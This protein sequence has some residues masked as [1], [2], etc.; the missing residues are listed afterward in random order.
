MLVEFIIDILI[1]SSYCLAAFAYLLNI[2]TA[3]NT[4]LLFISALFCSVLALTL[5]YLTR[6]RKEMT[7]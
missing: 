4:I 2:F 6:K 7:S 3:C 5:L 1:T